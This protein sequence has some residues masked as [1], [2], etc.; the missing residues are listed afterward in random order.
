M[1]DSTLTI[2]LDVSQSI[3]HHD[4]PTCTI[5]WAHRPE[6][7]GAQLNVSTTRQL[8]RGFAEFKHLDGRQVLIDDPY[9]SRTG[10]NTSYRESQGLTID[11]GDC[12]QDIDIDG[13][14]LEQSMLL[15]SDV[16]T[17]GTP[18]IWGNR[19]VLLFHFRNSA[20]SD[21]GVLHDILGV[22]ECIQ[23][24]KQSI[25]NLRV[26][27][28]SVL[29]T[30]PSGTGKE[31]IAQ[32]LHKESTRSDQPIV[33]VN[34]SAIAPELVASE[35][36]GHK[37]GAFTGADRDNK[38]LFEKAHRGSLFLDEIGDA[39]DKTQMALLRALEYG[40]I[41]P[42]GGDRLINVDV[43]AITATDAIL[44]ERIDNSSFR[45]PL[46]QRISSYT[47]KLDPLEQ[48]LEDVGILAL[49]YIRQ[50]E[51]DFANQYD[52]AA[53]T[54][55]TSQLPQLLYAFCRYS[56]P[57]N[58]RQLGNL[59]RQTLTDAIGNQQI[60]L[61]RCIQDHLDVVTPKKSLFRRKKRP[62][63]LNATEIESALRKHAWHPEHAADELGISR[64]ALL[65]RAKDDAIL[66][67][68]AE[69][70]ADDI[71]KALVKHGND[72]HDVAFALRITPKVLTRLMNEHQLEVTP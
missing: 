65:K 30:G 10:F 15:S 63:E 48:R 35:L 43:R 52:F 33:S 27:S 23:S 17:R 56:W 62:R 58:V 6:L 51:R 40:E 32:A 45:L 19:L 47:I 53:S 46:L 16:L 64:S 38:G 44:E 39:S 14:R 12:K 4:I 57:G 13:V 42:V 29:I 66:P 18:L 60:I 5:I 25:L 9:L 61:P 26:D 11:R 21:I 72:K 71:R 37:K 2:D 1:S 31:L 34:I 68:T 49:H 67:N 70:S 54:G 24:A 8:G 3:A 7:V 22:S 69:L 55:M 28:R 36:F 41:Q 50:H 59:I 20:T